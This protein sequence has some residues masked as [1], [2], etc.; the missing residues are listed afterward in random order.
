MTAIRRLSSCGVLLETGARKLATVTSTLFVSGLLVL[1]GVTTHP[2]TA[3]AQAQERCPLPPGVTPPPDPPITAREVV[4][5]ETLKNFALAVREQFKSQGSATVSAEQLA[6][7]GCRLRLEDGPFRSGSTYIVTLTPDGRVFL[8]SKDMSLSA[9][10]LK[11]SIYGGIL[12]A[13]GVSRTV[14]AGLASPDPATM[15]SA[16]DAVLQI[17]RSEQHGSFDL[18]NAV[19]G[20]RPGIPGASGYAAAYVSANTEQPM[21]LLVGF[22]LNAFHLKNEDID[23]GNPAITAREVVDRA[24]LKKFV[25]EALRFLWGTLSG[26]SSRDFRKIPVDQHD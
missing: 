22:D 12:A 13:L 21:L 10:S 24:T 1:A 16:Q 8:H 9:G 17:L 5:R 7:A 26:S 23:Y 2:V 11:S 20:V 14:L 19:A 15:R 18:T 4:D 3:L 25:T 6:Y